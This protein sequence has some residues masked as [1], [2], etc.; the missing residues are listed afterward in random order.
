MALMQIAAQTLPTTLAVG[1]RNKPLSTVA[2]AFQDTYGPSDPP[3]PMSAL[4]EVWRDF[5][6]NPA[7]MARRAFVDTPLAMG[8]SLPGGVKAPKVWLDA[9]GSG[10]AKAIGDSQG[11]DTLQ[12]NLK[13]VAETAGLKLEI[14]KGAPTVNWDLLTP[15]VL[16]VRHLGGSAALHEMVH[17]VQC[18]IG[19]A[20]ALG[21]A[22][23]AKFQAEHGRDARSAA[24]LRPYLAALTEAE[25]Q[26][27]MK[28][29]VKPM[30]MLAY[31]RFEETAFHTAG[32]SGKSSKDYDG[33]KK[34]LEE[35][36]AAFIKGYTLAE[37]PTVETRT[38]AKIYGGVAHVGRTHGETALLLAGAGAAYYGLTRA[39]M[40]IHPALML[41]MAAPLGYLL[42]RSMVSG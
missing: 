29:V 16:D 20:A 23:A 37:V 39:A 34:R 41:P 28:R 10:L 17:V 27:A 26:A 36:A 6:V 24:E 30:E 33:Y 38:D 9:L 7:A 1:L 31:S 5:G 22:A 25:K 32:M 13:A 42:Y 18:V 19:G 15:G 8:A 12:A 40:R 14:G 35:V 3:A 21:Q 11:L 4:A 2:A